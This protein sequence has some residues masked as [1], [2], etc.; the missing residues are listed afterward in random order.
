MLDV[1]V[2]N[3]DLVSADTCITKTVRM[4]RQRASELLAQKIAANVH[5]L[6]AGEAL[7]RDENELVLLDGLLDSLLLGLL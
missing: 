7:S 1:V 2:E 3:I 6:K 4:R 5:V